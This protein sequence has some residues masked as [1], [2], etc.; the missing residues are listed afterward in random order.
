MKDRVTGR[1]PGRTTLACR[2]TVDRIVEKA[3]CV[4]FDSHLTLCSDLFFKTL[5][6]SALARVQSL[7]WGQDET[8][9]NRWMAG[10]VTA[11]E[12]AYYLSA[13]LGISPKD[14][15]A[16]LREGCRQFIL[17]K[18]VWEF[19]QVVRAAGKRT[20]LVTV[21]ADVFSEEVVPSPRSGLRGHRQFR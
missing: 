11:S 10:Q 12:I 18:A 13:D 2:E 19:A 15:E 17:N 6:E 4:V 5:G 8:L 14:I 1:P 9:F 20:A 21:N 16:G 3:T 7:L